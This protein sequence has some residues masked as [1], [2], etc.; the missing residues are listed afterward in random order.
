MRT[1]VILVLA[2]L[3]VASVAVMIDTERQ[4]DACRAVAAEPGGKLR[5]APLPC[6]AG[7]ECR[8]VS[9]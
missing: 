3:W 1:A 9:T 5:P 8:K 7:G 4:L 2:L 6:W